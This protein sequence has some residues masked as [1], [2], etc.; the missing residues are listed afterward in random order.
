MELRETHSIGENTREWIVAPRDCPALGRHRIHLTGISDARLGFEFVRPD[1]PVSQILVCQSGE[2][3]ALIN[4]QWQRSGEGTA[5]VTPAHR[6]HAY[7]A[8]AR[9]RWLVCWLIYSELPGVAPLIGASD[10]SLLRVDPRPLFSAIQGLHWETAGAASAKV[11]EHSVE[12]IQLLVSRIVEPYRK[13]DRLWRVWTA[14]DAD[15]AHAW[16]LEELA[17]VGC[18]SPEHLRRLS[19]QQ[20]GRSPLAHIR[21]LRMRKAAALLSSTPDK[22]ETIGR[23]IGYENP[24]AFSTAFKHCMGASPAQFR[25]KEA[26]QGR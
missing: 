10:A 14:V 26:R 6:P 25:L 24:F 16:T 13:D 22:I 18:V 12:L 23:Q 2:G 11:M 20:L 3:R 1:S 17:E 5:Y 21:L 8:V 7:R 4:G 9:K 19:H 15:L